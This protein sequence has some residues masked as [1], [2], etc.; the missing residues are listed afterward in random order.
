MTGKITTRAFWIKEPGRGEIVE[1]S[2]PGPEAGEVVVRALCSGISRGTESLVFRGGVPRSQREVMRCPFQEGDFPAPVKYGY[3]SVGR[4]E[5]VVAPADAELD[6]R[7]VFCLHPHQD[8]YVVPGS[9]VVPLPEGLPAERA[10]LAANM[11]TAVNASWDASPATGDRVVVVGGGVVGLL[12]GWL[13]TKTP[14]S[15]VTLVD[16][17]PSREESADALGMGYAPHPPEGVDADLVIH[18]SGT[19]GGLRDALGTAGEEAT[20]V[21]LSW[22]GDHDVPLPLGE[23]F[24]SRRLTLRG[25]QVGRVPPSRSPRWDRR[26]RM[27]LALSLLTDPVLDVLVTDESPFE[28]LPLVMERLT[29]DGGTTLCHRIRYG[30]AACTS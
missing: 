25:S 21:E 3:A 2:A 30:G 9:A 15:E 24:H 5:E 20:V 28:E 11:E 27:E 26:R 6:G 4:V 12:T 19:A 13:L 17:E 14:G 10:V 8:R 16:P 18:A 29:A 22:F 23:A 1:G 7:T